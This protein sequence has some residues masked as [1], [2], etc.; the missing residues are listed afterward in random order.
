MVERERGEMSR[1]TKHVRINLKTDDGAGKTK[2]KTNSE[3]KQLYAIYAVVM[4]GWRE[5][6]EDWGRLH[7]HHK[8]PSHP[9]GN[10]NKLRVR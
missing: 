10:T 1:E 8:A 9:H 3:P 4:E 7:S 6:E 2:T 5:E